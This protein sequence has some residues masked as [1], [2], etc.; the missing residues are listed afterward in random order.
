MVDEAEDEGTITEFNY[1]I[2]RTGEGKQT[3]WSL[4]RLDKDTP[5]DDSGVEVFD[6]NETARRDIT[7]EDQ[8]RYYGSVYSGNAVP[9]TDN[10][11]PDA[12]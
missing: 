12:W 11:D 2:K 5:F 6:L 3:V 7:Y 1:R 10:A 4:K 8:A 9:A